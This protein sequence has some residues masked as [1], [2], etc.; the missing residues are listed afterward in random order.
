MARIN[1]IPLTLA[2]LSVF[3]S[4]HANALGLGDIT[5]HSGLNQPLDAEIALLE[6][7]DMTSDELIAKLASPAD[8]E[9]AGVDR[10]VFLQ[11][12]RF[13]PVIRNGRGY[14]K[15]VS[16]Q[17]VHEPYLNFL[18][19][20][21]R[22]NGRMLREY[23]VLID[24]PEYSANRSVAANV[25][26]SDVSPSRSSGYRPDIYRPEPVRR[27]PAQPPLP[28]GDGRYTTVRN[29][30]LWKISS[31]LTGSGA[32]RAQLMDSIVALNPQAFVNGDPHRLKVGQTLVLPQ[33]QQHVG[34]GNVAS[35]PQPA[36]AAPATASEQPT[37]AQQLP[38]T[39]A[40]ADPSQAQGNAAVPTAPAADASVAKVEAD[41]L[42]ANA[43]RDQMNQRMDDLQKQLVSLQQALQSRDQQV[44]S[45]QAELDRRQGEE[46]SGTV[47]G[48]N[49][50]AADAATGNAPTN[51][52]PAAPNSVAPVPQD[53]PAASAEQP[54]TPAQDAQGSGFNYWPWLGAGALG[55]LLVGL[56]FARRKREEK[57]VEMPPQRAA[58]PEPM[59]PVP[60]VKP[61]AAAVVAP[62]PTPHPVVVATPEPGVARLPA[63]S[64]DSLEGA[65]IYIAYGRFT[66]A[67]DMLR[68]AVNAEP[69]RREVR[70]KLLLVLA[71]LGD[72][73]GFH[74]EEH[75]LV[76]AGG[77]Q[78]QIDQLKSRY[79]A[80]LI[81]P[82]D[83]LQPPTGETLTDW[84]DLE[85]GEPV[86]TPV[87]QPRAAQDQ[88]DFAMNLSDLSLDLDW[89]K[90]DT[91]F[92]STRQGKA[93]PKAA[94]EVPSDFRSNLHE[95]PEI[96][97]LDLGEHGEM[98]GHGSKTMGVEEE[99]SFDLPDDIGHEHDELL[100]SLDRARQCIDQ[101]NLEEA[102]GIL[103]QVIASGDSKAKAEARELLALIA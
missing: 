55:A 60:Q 71:E 65:D 34:T 19:A 29:D 98:F 66:Q 4:A 100:A 91:P 80:M 56:L 67:R 21:E 78:K 103:K 26:G 8:Y 20:V 94:Q 61:L 6:T 31:Q 35:A 89:D 74:E 81:R 54:V 99:L 49:A 85:L 44:Q 30:T 79:P 11:N 2:A 22:P 48:A 73:A 47:P 59:K 58:A 7:G 51:A 23:T 12:L 39:A 43:Q 95:L 72:V 41:L 86:A 96:T 40:A 38:A 50:P 53:T 68:K 87:E 88:P 13:T 14:I 24:P 3:V 16:T 45:L 10:F 17:P 70:M 69:N 15:V 75:A 5:L 42:L 102:Y 37:G 1:R 32:S 33:G 57:P 76:A 28:A 46:A 63:A 27:A 83:T 52:V 82:E 62:V 18:I 90:L 36:S 77:D 92:E 93:A 25:G 101:G 9:N 64:A 84:D 97:E